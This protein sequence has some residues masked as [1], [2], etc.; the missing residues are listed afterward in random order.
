MR[1]PVRAYPYI[2]G[3]HRPIREVLLVPFS[4]GD[5]LIGTLWVVAHSP[6]KRFDAE[7]LRIVTS[8][9]RFAAL[10]TKALDE[11]DV[12]E[13]TTRALALE[14]RR[15]TEFLATLGHELRNPLAPIRNALELIKK[16]A[17]KA[18]LVVPIMERQVSHL[19]RLIDDLLDISRITSDKLVLRR[20]RVG[21]SGIVAQAV[22]ATQAQLEGSAHALSVAAPENIHIDVDPVRMTQVLTNLLTNASKYTPHGG[23]I[24]LNVQVTERSVSIAVSDSGIGIMPEQMEHIFDLFGQEHAELS[25]GGL[26]VGLALARRLVTLHGG[27]LTARSAGPGLGSTFEVVLPRV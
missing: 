12:L 13:Q 23:R 15:K 19:V 21:V 25:Q 4:R 22:E 10:V 14:N 1:E 9:A 17:A 7:D 20:E 5:Q 11:R 27:E 3:L 18:P 8:L 24:A 26:G 2:S 16:D 6:E